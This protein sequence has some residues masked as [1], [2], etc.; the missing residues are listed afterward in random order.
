MA[1][2]VRR[3]QP[4]FYL[5][6]TKRKDVRKG[7]LEALGNLSLE[8]GLSATGEGLYTADVIVLYIADKAHEQ[9]GLETVNAI[10]AQPRLFLK[11]LLALSERH[12]EGFEDVVDEELILPVQPGSLESKIERLLSI[13]R[14]A[15]GLTAAQETLSGSVLS[16]ILLLQ[17]LYTRDNY[18][19]KPRR[20]ACSSL[21]Y[22]YPLVQS[23]LNGSS[24]ADVEVMEGLERSFLL[25]WELEDKVNLCPYCQHF[26]INF[27]EICPECRS[28]EVKEEATIHHF[29]CAC[30]GKETDFREGPVLRCPKCRKELRHIGV[31]YDRPTED[32]WC[33]S[34]GS[35][36]Y[37][38]QVQCYCINCGKIFPPEESLLK[39]IKT[40][41]LTP[42]GVSAA[43]SGVLPGVGLMNLLEGEVY[44]YKYDVFKEF[45]R[46]E[47]LRCR[48]YKYASSLARV[49]MKNFNEIL[50]AKGMG[51]AQSFTKEFATI[52]KQTF[53]ETD[54]L[55]ELD[56]NNFLALCTNCGNI[57]VRKALERL[58][59]RCNSIF[60]AK[61]DL[62]YNIID[63]R[64]E[65]EDLEDV[66]EDLK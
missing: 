49:T 26:Q 25:K 3:K 10:K 62:D 33:A 37:E 5:L 18:L 16:Q 44:L 15:N 4:Q 9:W 6:A 38:T 66:L 61:L 42:E 52:F 20:D 41:S 36:F 7:L 32:L 11:P 47:V 40:Y 19:L 50:Q 14:R 53:R 39:Y 57:N 65:N 22:S 2:T 51:Y 55:T 17:F 34:C 21:G 60:K 43:Q 58:R 23:L 8:V 24:G 64:T 27:R 54:I 63:L 35:N 59:E 56:A 1:K 45:F 30:V 28:L 31:D 29:R 12:L 46:L 48:R 13:S